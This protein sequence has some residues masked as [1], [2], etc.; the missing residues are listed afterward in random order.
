M[1]GQKTTKYRGDGEF[2]DSTVDKISWES[3]WSKSEEIPTEGI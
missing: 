2:Q 3:W 1:K